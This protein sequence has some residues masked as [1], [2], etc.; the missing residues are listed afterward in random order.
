MGAPRGKGI[1]ARAP[2][3]YPGGNPGAY[4]VALRCQFV[5][6]HDQA[7]TDDD[8]RRAADLGLQTF[9]YSMPDSWLPTNWGAT[10]HRQGERAMKLG[11]AGFI[12]D[13]ERADQ[14]RNQRRARQVLG[15]ALANAAASLPSVG[16]TSI[17]SWYLD[18][19][20][21]AAAAAGVWGSP[22]LYGIVSPV[23][24]HEEFSRRAAPW[25]RLFG[26]EGVVPSLAAWGRA[27][28]G[29]PAP[30]TMPPDQ[31]E[32]MAPF[33]GERGG[34]FWQAPSQDRIRPW[35]GT[36]GFSLLRD[37]RFGASAW[38]DLVAVLGRSMLRAPAPW[39]AHG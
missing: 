29:A 20:A 3:Y 22:Q 16:F 26:A 17:P 13:V 14:W 10:L 30:E 37:F 18:D 38:R 27:P 19:V 5:A 11:I 24:S 4:A 15:Q 1:Y 2:R 21:P 34:I 35:P 9:L 36:A 23:R 6:L 7:S 8:V 25:R 33:V 12:A 31:A 28:I 32:Y 39:R